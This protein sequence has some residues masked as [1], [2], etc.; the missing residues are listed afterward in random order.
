MSEIKKIDTKKYTTEGKIEVD[1]MVW[2]VKLPGGGKELEMSKAQRRVK[3]YEKKIES[4]DYTEEDLDKLD[5]LE[6]FFV[7]FFKEIFRDSTPENSE[8]DKWIDETPQALILM[9]LEDIK[10]QANGPLNES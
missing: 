4:G 8:V 3:F 1:G 7:S 9:A 10:K 6:D 5:T 2:T